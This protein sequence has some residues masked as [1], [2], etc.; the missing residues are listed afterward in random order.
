M[1]DG[2]DPILNAGNSSPRLSTT[3]RLRCTEIVVNAMGWSFI[4]KALFGILRWAVGIEQDSMGRRYDG[5]RVVIL[6]AGALVRKHVVR[7][8]V[9]S[10]WSTYR[11]LAFDSWAS[12][13]RLTGASSQFCFTGQ[14]RASKFRPI[15]VK[16]VPKI[17]STG[18][19]GYNVVPAHG[20]CIWSAR[21]SSVFVLDDSKSN[22]NDGGLGGCWEC[23][24]TC[25]LYVL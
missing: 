7:I 1:I 25:V 17:V 18:R 5:G 8:A 20:G 15:L 19:N 23:G 16:I 21:R 9:Q 2:C 24:Q 12:T 14:R 11:C 22:N 10:D 13:T 4:Q 3:L 6:I